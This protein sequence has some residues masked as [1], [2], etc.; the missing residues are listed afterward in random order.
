MV[1]VATVVGCSE[2]ACQSGVGV[3]LMFHRSVGEQVTMAQ[4]AEG[5]FQSL[6]IYFL[7]LKYPKVAAD[8]AAGD[9]C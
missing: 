9:L 5:R 6:I 2:G 7:S 8:L 4:G 1:S 3:V